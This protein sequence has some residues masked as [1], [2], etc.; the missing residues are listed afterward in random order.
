MKY[1][2]FMIGVKPIFR[3]AVEVIDGGLYCICGPVVFC[4]SYS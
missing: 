1:L 3:F 2:R 4:V